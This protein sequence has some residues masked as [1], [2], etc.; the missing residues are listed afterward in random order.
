MVILGILT[1]EEIGLAALFAL[2]FANG[3][4]RRGK[5]RGIVDYAELIGGAS[6]AKGFAVGRL[7]HRSRKCHSDS[8][9]RQALF[10]LH[11]AESFAEHA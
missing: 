4:E 2:A 11:S 5:E 8:D 7:L 10:G 1:V 9:L 6:R 3:G